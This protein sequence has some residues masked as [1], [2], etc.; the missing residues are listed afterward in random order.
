MKSKLSRQ[1]ITYSAEVAEKDGFQHFMMK[2]IHE[3]PKASQDT[4]NSVI[5]E[6]AIRFSAVG[7]SDKEIQAISQ[8]YIIACD[9]A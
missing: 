9:S 8:L 1:E 5:K 2:E 3:H 7:L 4:L 6:N